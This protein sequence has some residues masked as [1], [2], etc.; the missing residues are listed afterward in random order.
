M[1]SMAADIRILTK[2][3]IL[4]FLAAIVILCS[5]I[6]SS[7]SGTGSC[8]GVGGDILFSPVCK[9]DWTRGECQEWD[10]MQ[11]NGAEWSYMGGETCED[12]GYTDRCSD[13]SFRLPGD[14]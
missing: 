3:R 4:V 5:L 1:N 2:H 13:G 12:L 10:D 7:C 8:V 6:L 11:V 9:N 14:C